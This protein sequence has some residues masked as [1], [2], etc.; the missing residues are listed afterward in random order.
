M[1]LRDAA[2]RK[3]KYLNTWLPGREKKLRNST[4]VI[5]RKPLSLKLYGSNWDELAKRVQRIQNTCLR[6]IFL[7]YSNQLTPCDRQLSISKLKERRHFH[8]LSFQ[9]T[10]FFNNLFYTN[11]FS[12]LA[13]TMFATLGKQVTFGHLSHS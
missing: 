9:N 4:N 1:K 10:F 11:V 3:F 13:L 7:K 8:K 2:F 12:P 5:K 6:F